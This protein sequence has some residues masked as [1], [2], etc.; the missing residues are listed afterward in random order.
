MILFQFLIFQEIVADIFQSGV[1]FSE[2]EYISLVSLRTNIVV[3]DT[4]TESNMRSASFEVEK[5]RAVLRQY[6][7]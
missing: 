2:T 3:I 6:K 5:I 7:K 1:R 4:E